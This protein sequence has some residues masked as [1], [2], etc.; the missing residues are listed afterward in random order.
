MKKLIFLFAIITIFSSC[1]GTGEKILPGSSGRTHNIL[2]VM[3]N[4]DWKSSVG[5]S[6]RKYFAAEFADLPQVEPLFSLKQT[7]RD[8]YNG[9]Y[10]VVRNVLV[11]KEGENPGI[12]FYKNKYA[13]PQ[14][15]TVIEG[16]NIDQLKQ[17]ISKHSKEI[18]TRYE[19]A[20]IE[21][22]QAK[23]RKSLRDNS[24][25]EKELNVKIN[26]PDF[27]NLVDHQDKFF[28][29]RRDIKNGEQDILLYQV[30]LQDSL[31]YSGERVTIYR[32][33]IC[34][35]YIPGPTENTYMKTD[36]NLSPSQVFTEINNLKAIETRGHW[37][38]KNDFMGGPYVNYSIIDKQNNR[39]V[40]VE[41]FIYAPAVD[42]RDY[43]VQL[44]AIL[45][46][47]RLK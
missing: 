38:M 22:L 25:I 24:D 9:V 12:R 13:K 19:I 29:F 6:I 1:S 7:T 34:K 23:H 46:T 42:K 3:D 32:D 18:I 35:K 15:I 31:D 36:V 4:S 2:L 28:W 10:K 20:E 11:V 33:S 21:N 41:G 16:E 40:V 43:M 8:M 39:M 14:L 5:D 30:P 26:I 17:L 27:F 47:V 37:N 44:E 45:K